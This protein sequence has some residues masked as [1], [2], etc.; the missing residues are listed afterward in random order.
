MGSARFLPRKRVPPYTR[1]RLRGR[2][3]LCGIGVMS[4][5]AVIENP[6]ACRARNALSRPEPGPETSISS[7]SMPCSRAFLPASSAATC[8]A[9]GVDLRLPLKPWLPEDDQAIALPCASVMVIIVLLNVAAT[10]ATPE[11]MFLRSFLRVRVPV[12]CFAIGSG[13]VQNDVRRPR[14]RSTKSNG[15]RKAAVGKTYFVTFFL[16]AI[17]TALPLRVRALVWV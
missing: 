17:A 13:P 4:R 15:R 9:Y 16:P 14:G 3:P 1:R 8:A 12:A 2:Q 10:W 7:V 11:V 5:M 6:T